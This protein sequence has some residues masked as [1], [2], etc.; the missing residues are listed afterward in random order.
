[1]QQAIS[2]VN[3]FAH[4][5]RV[6]AFT[7]TT[8]FALLVAVFARISIHVP[9]TPVP[10]TLQPM[11][12]MLTGLVL[13]SRL[14]FLALLEYFAFGALG[15]PVWAG[16]AAGINLTTMSSLGY[17]LSYPIAAWAVGHVSER[18]RGRLGQLLLA[19]LAGLCVTY[20]CGVCYL[21]GWLLIVKDTPPS[22]ILGQALLLG[23]APF[24]LPDLAKAV[25]ASAIAR[26]MKD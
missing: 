20:V 15:A 11:A 24:I 21:A 13:G 19:S 9:F 23:A 6:S 7:T 25:I 5:G 3:V 1:M 2:R 8:L 10:F 4:S 12:V 16:G 18:S 26:S 22:Q 14:G 17:L